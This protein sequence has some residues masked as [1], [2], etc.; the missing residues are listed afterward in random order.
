MSTLNGTY[1]SFLQSLDFVFWSAQQDQCVVIG[2]LLRT[3][4]PQLSF[5]T[6]LTNST[7][8]RPFI[9]HM[10]CEEII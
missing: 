2:Q 9:L 3:C 1:N 7:R 5:N 4:L 6:L 8:P 10:H